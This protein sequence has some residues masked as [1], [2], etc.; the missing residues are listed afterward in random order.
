MN[1]ENTENTENTA[2]VTYCKITSI[3]C[4]N[5]VNNVFSTMHRDD[6]IRQKFLISM[7]LNKD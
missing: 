1:T 3:S 2:F 4:E 6:I 5:L 7:S